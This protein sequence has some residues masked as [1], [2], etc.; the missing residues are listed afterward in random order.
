MPLLTSVRDY[1]RRVAVGGALSGLEAA[2]FWTQPQAA[3]VLDRALRDLLSP[4][5]LGTAAALADLNL[6]AYALC[7]RARR[8]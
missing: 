3:R 5:F 2:R 1:H 4:D 7:M 8:W 6:L